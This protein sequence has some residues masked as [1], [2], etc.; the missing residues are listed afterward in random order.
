MLTLSGR[1]LALVLVY[2]AHVSSHPA[3]FLIRYQKDFRRCLGSE[4][5]AK[6]ALKVMESC[7]GIDTTVFKAHSVRGAAATAFLASGIDQAL[8]RQ[9]G[10]GGQTLKLLRPTMPD[11][12]N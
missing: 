2:L 1:P 4:A 9:R 6:A 12:I 7:G 11:C 10:W 5:V 8:T 3:P